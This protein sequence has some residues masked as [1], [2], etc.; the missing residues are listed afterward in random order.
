MEDIPEEEIPYAI[1]IN[2]IANAI[3]IIA[4]TLPKLAIGIMLTRILS[5][6]KATT[7][8]FIVPAVVMILYAFAHVGIFVVY[9][10]ANPDIVVDS[11]ITVSGKLTTLSMRP[12]STSMLTAALKL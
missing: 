3:S 11:A 4:F 7:A 5:M 6:R 9:A 10:T 2:T 12:G 1:Q 8:L